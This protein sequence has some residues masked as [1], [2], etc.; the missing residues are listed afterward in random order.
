MRPTVRGKIL[1]FVVVGRDR[2]HA[3]LHPEEKWQ[4]FSVTGCDRL[5]RF[6]DYVVSSDTHREVEIF[7]RIQRQNVRG[8]GRER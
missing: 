4:T 7:C 8:D 5:W 6:V 3:E 1:F 2:L